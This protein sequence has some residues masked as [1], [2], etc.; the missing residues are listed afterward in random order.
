MVRWVKVRSDGQQLHQ[1]LPDHVTQSDDGSLSFRTV[2]S[3]DAGNYTCFAENEQGIISAT[4]RV[5][6]VGKSDAFRLTAT[7]RDRDGTLL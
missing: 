7:V 5:D 3:G 1:A 6:I 2:E 4:I